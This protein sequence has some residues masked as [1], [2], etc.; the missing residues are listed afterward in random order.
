VSDTFE[1]E[2]RRS[3]DN[4]KKILHAAGCEISDVVQTRN[5]V[6]DSED[7][8]QFNHLYREYFRAPFPARTTI[9]NCLP[10]SLKYEIEVVAIVP[11]QGTTNV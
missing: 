7:L 1:G 2:F 3:L 9:V 6:R 8:P 10:A 4:V 5:Y 11:T